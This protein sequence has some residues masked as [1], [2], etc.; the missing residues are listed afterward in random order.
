M[1]GNR[2]YR[3]IVKGHVQGVGFRAMTRHFARKNSLKGSVRNTGDG[4][5]E[6]MLYGPEDDLHLMIRFCRSSPGLS[7]VEEVDHETIEDETLKQHFK[8]LQGFEITH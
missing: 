2:L 7:R 8:K 3:L 5:V 1:Q 4:D 6:I